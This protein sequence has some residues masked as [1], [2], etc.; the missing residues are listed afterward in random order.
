MV[1]DF[2]AV[3][4]E[5]ISSFNGIDVFRINTDKFKTSSIHFFF[6]D[7]LTRA[8][9]TKNAL[10]PAVIRR[11]TEK[12]PTLR[13]ISMKLE[14]LYGASFDCGVTKKGERHIMHFYVDFLSKQYVPGG[15]DTF[16]EGLGLLWDVITKPALINGKFNEDYLVQE[17]DK[18]RILIEG[19]VNDKMQYSVDRCLEEVCRNEPF[20]IYDYGF[21]EDIEAITSDELTAHYRTM[22]ESFPLQVWLAGNI[23]DSE[24]DSAVRLLKEL[25]RRNIVTLLNGFVE[26]EKPEPRYVTETMNVTQGKLCLG[27]R[28]N[29]AAD[30]G[31]YPALM[32]FNSILGGGVHSK[33]FQNVREKA[34]LAYYAY[35]RLDKFKGLMVISSGIEIGNKGKA[36]EIISR[37]LDDIANG[38]VSDQELETAV[39]SIETG[40]KSLTDSQ[41]SMVDFYLSQTVSGTRDDFADI[42]KK[43]KTVKKDDVIRI[44]R[45]VGLDTV[46]FLTGPDTA[47]QSR[48]IVN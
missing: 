35:S 13:D 20:G 45:R 22:L 29:T 9:V 43:V 2:N 46:Y 5:S 7:N 12:Y 14:N 16:S 41:H 6:Q 15:T 8:N 38:I 39:K 3:K 48:Q 37:Q 27:Y 23:T 33:L 4:A 26:K 47:V 28:T 30:S 42:M 32:V 31:D 21:K 44:S 17:K 1:K 24:A 19:R 25:P 34:S 11:G 40:L 36:L 18:L 10:L